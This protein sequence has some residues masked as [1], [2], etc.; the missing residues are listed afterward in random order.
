MGYNIAKM[1]FKGKP[2]NKLFFYLAISVL[3]VAL[4]V[5]LYSDKYSNNVCADEADILVLLLEDRDRILDG[6]EFRSLYTNDYKME[7][8]FSEI[9]TNVDSILFLLE[10]N[11]ILQSCITKEGGSWVV[12]EINSG[13]FY[14]DYNIIGYSP[15]ESPEGFECFN[16]K[17]IRIEPLGNSYYKAVARSYMD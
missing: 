7:S 6:R 13:L 17:L 14:I 4:Y 8:N 1:V 15:N 5:V 2:I 12:T 16:S 10:K 9:P 11:S 3:S